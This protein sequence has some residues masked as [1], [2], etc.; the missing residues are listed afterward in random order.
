MLRQFER[1]GLRLTRQFTFRSLSS[2]GPVRDSLDSV[3]NTKIVMAEK[4]HTTGSP[5]S[6]SE[7]EAARLA[8]DAAIGKLKFL[9]EKWIPYAELM[10]LEKP[11]G[12]LFLLIPSFWGI[13]MASFSIGAPFLTFFSAVSLFSIGAVIMRGA[14]CTINDLLDR[15]LDNKVAR[16]MERPITSGRVSVPEAVVFLAA[17]CF[18]GLGVLLSLPSDCLLLGALSLPFVASYPLFKRFTYYPQVVLSTCFSWGCLLGFPAVGAPLAL[19]VSV[20]LYISNWIW[21]MTYDTVYA[22]QD[23]KFDVNA[24]IKSTALAWGDKT[25]PITYGL[26]TLQASAFALSGFMNGMGPG[27]YIGGIWGFYRLFRQLKEVNLDDPKS[28]WN[29]FTGNINTGFVF[30]FGMLFDYILKLGGFL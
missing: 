21:C 25:K 15:N 7:L 4:L 20:P 17:Q 12:T 19:W 22:H 1:S 18:I 14:G 13:T 28:C 26:L 30:W 5:F 6:A 2:V 16:T 10:R 3:N 11:A 23:K 29:F 9:P 8:R 24:G 27:F